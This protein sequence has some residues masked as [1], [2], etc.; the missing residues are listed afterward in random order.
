MTGT[1]GVIGARAVGTYPT[2]GPVPAFN[3]ALH[4]SAAR[5]SAPAARP[6]V[7]TVTTPASDGGLFMPAMAPTP[8]QPPLQQ[9]V[10][11]RPSV[12]GPSP[13]TVN[14]VIPWSYLFVFLAFSV[15]AL[16]M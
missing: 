1:M 2:A 13:T 12:S 11:A 10:G 8:P 7:T 3:P 5:P 6:P 4:P 9:P 16:A 15:F 14:G